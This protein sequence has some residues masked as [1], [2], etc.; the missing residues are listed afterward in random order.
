MRPLGRP[1]TGTGTDDGR[2][3]RRREDR[4]HGFLFL[5]EEDSNGRFGLFEEII[6]P[7]KMLCGSF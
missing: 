1:G 6:D 7:E 3:G 4:H 5:F 2:M